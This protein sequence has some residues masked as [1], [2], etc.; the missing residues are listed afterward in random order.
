M[1]QLLLL[2]GSNMRL[3]GAAQRADQKLNNIMTADNRLRALAIPAP[4]IP[5]PFLGLLPVKSEEDL[6]SVEKLLSHD[7]DDID[8]TKFKK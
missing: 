5:S 8:A 4:T 6:S 2:N 1:T 7:N 3:C